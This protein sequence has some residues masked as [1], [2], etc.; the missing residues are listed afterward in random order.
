[1]KR[2]AQ[3]KCL[4]ILRRYKSLSFTVKYLLHWEPIKLKF[5]RSEPYII[6]Y[7]KKWEESE[8]NTLEPKMEYIKQLKSK[9]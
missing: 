5:P 3:K 2:K 1:M 4:K 8:W 9:E 7:G 6:K